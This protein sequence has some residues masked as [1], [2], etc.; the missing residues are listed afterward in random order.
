[1]LRSASRTSICAVQ[2]VKTEVWQQ[3]VKTDDSLFWDLAGELIAAGKVEEGVLMRS[4][5]V[6][7]QGEFVAMAEY[8]V[9][10]LVVKLPAARVASLIDDG[11]GLP[12]APAKKVFKEWVQ[13]PERDEVLWR[14]LL[15]EAI[16]F[17]S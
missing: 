11:V 10:D 13:V 17:A 15:D 6:R 9:G 16:E 3:S 12:F 14:S 8:R 4:R 2:S 1:M 5:C 7:L